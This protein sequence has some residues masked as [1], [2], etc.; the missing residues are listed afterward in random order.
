MATAIFIIKFREANFC[1][2]AMLDYILKR[3]SHKLNK[4]AMFSILELKKF[5]GP[6]VYRLQMSFDVAFPLKKN[7]KKKTF[8]KCVM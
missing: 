2:V 8:I 1:H 4:R 6:T 3:Y 5:Q 7:R